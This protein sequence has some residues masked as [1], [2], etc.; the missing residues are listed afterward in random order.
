MLSSTISK[1]F[2]KPFSWRYYC[3]WHSVW[4]YSILT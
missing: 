1:H 2:K 3:S 4:D